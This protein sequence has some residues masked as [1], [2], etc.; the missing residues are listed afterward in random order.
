MD[1]HSEDKVHSGRSGSSKSL[2]ITRLRII[3]RR[4]HRG[5]GIAESV[6]KHVPPSGVQVCFPERKCFKKILKWWPYNI[7]YM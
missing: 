1:L 6:F 2:Q 4:K 3:R 5:R 7:L